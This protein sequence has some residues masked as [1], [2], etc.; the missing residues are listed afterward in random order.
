MDKRRKRSPEEIEAIRRRRMR[1][2]RARRQGS[3]PNN[4]RIESERVGRPNSPSKRRPDNNIPVQRRRTDSERVNR[5]SVNRKP[6]KG[7]KKKVSTFKKIATG[8]ALVLCIIILIVGANIIRFFSKIENNCSVDGIKPS[9]GECTNILVLGLD[10][11]AVGL[12]EDSSIKR[13]DTM[14]LVSYNPSS[15]ATNIISI[16]RD[17]LI[18]ENGKSYKIN[19]A[20]PMGGDSK[21][22]N[23]VENLLSTKI[24]Y[25]VKVDYEAFR[26]II[27]AIGGVDMKIEQDMIY[28]DD[29]QNLHINFKGGTIEHLDGQKAEEF[30]RWRK[31]N[32]GTG[33]ATG[34]LG[35]IE[36]QHKL[37][38]KV[39]DKI[40]SPTIIFKMSKIL[41]SIAVNIDTNMSGGSMFSTALK[42]MTSDVNM[43]TL[44]GEGKMIG[45]VSYFVLYKDENAELI[46]AINGSD[47]KLDSFNKSSLR[48]LVENG[49]NRNKLAARGKSLLQGAGWSSIDVGNG[50]LTKKSIIYCKNKDVFESIEK[51]LGDMKT[52]TDIPE[53]DRY[54]GYDII[55]ILG[56]DYSK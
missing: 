52:S 18:K 50:D 31:N 30:F 48:I 13:T 26:D 9:R 39:V 14:L 55:I 35:R 34:D 37:M 16:P 25:L 44:K 5:E 46:E 19:S 4:R 28:D 20:Y 3:S 22:I 6:R 23:V 12:E 24:N 54:E 8:I 43:T 53:K 47:I 42:V 7:S 32:D 38:S 56:D 45:G 41:D 33:L 27:D 21:V 1:E 10:I 36:N 17:T 2:E 40:K 15:K 49:T 51:T 29:A 11:G